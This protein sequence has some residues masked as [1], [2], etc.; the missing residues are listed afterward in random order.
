MDDDFRSKLQ[1][2]LSDPDALSRIAAIA[3]SLGAEKQAS[4]PF[5]P[6]EAEEPSPPPEAPP[7]TR[8]PPKPPSPAPDPRIALLNSLK[9][10]LREEKR[11]KIDALTRALAVAS[12]FGPI[13][14]G[15]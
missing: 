6:P 13:T 5:P 14:G 3:G 10:L 2:V 11:E 15:K 4:P 8:L 1:Y 12:L 9:P 7:Q